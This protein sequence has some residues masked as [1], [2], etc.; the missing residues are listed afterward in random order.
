MDPGA[1]FLFS[2]PPGGML[3]PGEDGPKSCPSVLPDDLV[4][5]AAVPL[6]AIRDPM[7]TQSPVEAG[8]HLDRRCWMKR[9]LV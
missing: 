9:G 7:I 4:L 2:T 6:P 1:G 8:G 5:V 3:L